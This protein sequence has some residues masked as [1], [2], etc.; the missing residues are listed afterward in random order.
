[1]NAITEVRTQLTRMAPELAKVLPDHVSPERFERI[2]LTALQRAPDLLGCDRKSLFES[3]MQCAQDGLIPDGREAALTKFGNK[4][5]YMP[6]VAGILKKVRQS[7]ELSTITAHI[8]Y[9]GDEFRYWIDDEGEHLTHTPDLMSEQTEALGVYALAR[10]KDGGVYIEVLRMSEVKK[11]RSVSR[12]ANNGPWAQWFE[13][14]AKK[15]AIRRLAK[16]LPM[17]TDVEN[18]IQRDDQF[19]PYQEKQVA[20]A[21]SAISALTAADPEPDAIDTDTGEIIEADAIERDDA[22]VAPTSAAA[23]AGDIF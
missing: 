15:S 11:I 8:I 13:Q 5:A 1:M 12:G 7:G 23:A 4:V 9:K 14:M 17:S 3:V 16:R 18:V 19:Y 20:Q 21:T 2:T 10:T 22:S 6:M